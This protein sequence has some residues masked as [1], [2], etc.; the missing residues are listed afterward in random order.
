M[1]QNFLFTPPHP[2]SSFSRIILAITLMLLIPLLPYRL[3]GC[4]AQP[5]KLPRT[6]FTSH[7]I[8]ALILLNT[9]PAPLPRTLFRRLFNRALAR[10]L[11]LD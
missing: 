10:L 7:V 4:Q 9:R 1:A 3:K 6:R 2:S 11:L 5:A 8:A